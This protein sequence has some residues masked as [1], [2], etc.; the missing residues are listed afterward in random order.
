MYICV[1]VALA[2]SDGIELE[3]KS[4]PEFGK[5][6]FMYVRLEENVC[7]CVCC[8]VLSTLTFRTNRALKQFRISMCLLVLVVL[9]VVTFQSPENTREKRLCF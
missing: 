8:K 2:S 9:N 5:D 1:Y 7:V 3:T 6:R 4:D